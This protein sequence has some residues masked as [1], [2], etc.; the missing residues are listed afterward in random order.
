MGIANYSVVKSNIKDSLFCAFIL[1]QVQSDDADKKGKNE[2]WDG[3]LTQVREILVAP[4]PKQIFPQGQ[5]R[6]LF[7][8]FG[9]GSCCL[10]EAGLC[11]V[12]QFLIQAQGKL[13][14]R[15]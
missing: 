4:A 10:P 6:S 13:A 12:P 7:C 2:L 9:L 8:S 1:S 15:K 11:F 14:A 5:T 3:D